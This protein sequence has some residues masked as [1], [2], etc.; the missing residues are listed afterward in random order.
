MR[1]VLCFVLMI[2][3]ISACSESSSEL[4]F[5]K[6]PSG[7][8]FFGADNASEAEGPLVMCRM[9]S[10]QLSITEISNEQ[11]EIFVEETGYL[12]N[13][14]TKGGMV[15]NDEWKLMKTANWRMPEGKV[16]DREKWKNLPVVQISYLDALAYCTWA[17]YR[18]PTEIEW[19]YASKLGKS[20]SVQMNITS[21]ESTYSKTMNVRSLGKNKLG[22]YHQSGNVWEW[23]LDSYNSEIHD[24]LQLISTTESFDPFQG[25]SFDPEKIDAKDTLRVIKGGS[26]L[27]QK[28]YCAG[29]RP[30]ARQSAEQS[31]AYFHVGFRVVKNTR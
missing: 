8:F 27:C 19:E 16:L 22:V 18:L 5:M 24:K 7:A 23:C 6:I 29:Y 17:E 14:E 21:A 3:L 10:F 2:F 26:F 31:E 12:T 30:E 9:E 4:K 1:K 13:A 15:F 28:G 11:F 20:S 25:R